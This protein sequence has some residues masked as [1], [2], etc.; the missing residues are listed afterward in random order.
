MVR[1]L[2]VV[3]KIND[4]DSFKTQ[5]EELHAKML[6]SG[7]DSWCVS[8]MSLDHEMARVDLMEKASVLDDGKY[9]IEEIVGAMDV[10]NK[11]IDDFL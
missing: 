8:A 4:E 9:I 1:Y 2:T 7:D 3:F 11:N 10:G 6:D 5:K